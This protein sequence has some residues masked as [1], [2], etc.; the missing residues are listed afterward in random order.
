V[1]LPGFYKQVER[2]IEN[3]ALQTKTARAIVRKAGLRPGVSSELPSTSRPQ[4]VIDAWIEPSVSTL[5]PEFEYQWH[6]DLTGYTHMRATCQHFTGSSVLVYYSLNDTT[7]LDAG[8][9]T[10]LISASS[11]S[12]QDMSVPLGWVDIEEELRRPLRTTIGLLE[13]TFVPNRPDFLIYGASSTSGPFGL[14]LQVR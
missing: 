13:A 4:T 8:D 10:R 6:I 7:A 3:T 1:S 2:M 9:W 5:D 11:F 14:A 12:H